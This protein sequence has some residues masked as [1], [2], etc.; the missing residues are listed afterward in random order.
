MQYLFL[1]YGDDLR[2]R[3]EA[4]NEQLVRRHSGVIRDAQSSG[5]FVAAEPLKSTRFATTVRKQSGNPVVTDGPFI[6]SKEQL[7]G[8]YILKLDTREEAIEWAGRIPAGPEGCEGAV[9]IRIFPGLRKM[10]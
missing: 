5:V 9:E 2:Y 8:Y 3:T 1:I 6:E 10:I 7:I 4:E